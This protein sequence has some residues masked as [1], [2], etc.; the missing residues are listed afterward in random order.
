MIQPNGKVTS[1][2]RVTA[3]VVNASVAID[4]SLALMRRVMTSRMALAVAEPNGS[5]MAI[6]KASPVGR[7]MMMTPTNPMMTAVQR[8][9]PTCSPRIGGARAVMM[10]GIMNVTVTTSARGR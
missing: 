2:A 9:Q 6:C 4:D 1:P 8:R 10:I 3:A 5:M 7:T